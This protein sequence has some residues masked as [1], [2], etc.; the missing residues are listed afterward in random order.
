MALGVSKL[1]V[2]KTE[3]EVF[4]PPP[5]GFLKEACI[6]FLRNVT[7]Q[8]ELSGIRPIYLLHFCQ[9]FSNLPS[10]IVKNGPEKKRTQKR[11]KK[12]FLVFLKSSFFPPKRAKH[13]VSTEKVN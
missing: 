6:R 12:A 5:P 9:K 7:L 8:K 1:V 11:A 13:A 10:F 4:Q 3:R 2:V